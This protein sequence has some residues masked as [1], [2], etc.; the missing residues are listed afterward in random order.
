MVTE[1]NIT[2]LFIYLNFMEKKHIVLW[3]L[4]IDCQHVFV[5]QCKQKIHML[6]LLKIISSMCNIFCTQNQIMEWGSK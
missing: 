1:I 3:C 2:A 4:S 5:C 6:A